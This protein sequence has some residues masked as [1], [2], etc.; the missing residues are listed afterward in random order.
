MRIAIEGMDGVGK[1]TLAK[2]LVEKLDYECV[3]KPFK[4][5]FDDLFNEYIL[6][7]FIYGKLLNSINYI[8]SRVKKEILEMKQ[9][10]K[11]KINMKSLILKNILFS[12][13]L[14]YSYYR[15][16]GCRDEEQI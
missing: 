6:V 12:K 13:I 1:T 16:S 10:K 3:D 7:G 14:W 8:V 9:V 4:F 15:E 2:A 11:S 5:L